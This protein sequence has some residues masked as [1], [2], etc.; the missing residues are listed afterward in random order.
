[1]SDGCREY[2]KNTCAGCERLWSCE[3]AEGIRKALR[4]VKLFESEHDGSRYRRSYGKR[5]RKSAASLK[6]KR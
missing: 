5:K 1:M 2:G 3:K 6:I 4:E